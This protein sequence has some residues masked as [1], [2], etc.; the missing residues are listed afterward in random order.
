MGKAAVGLAS[1]PFIAVLFLGISLLTGTSID[2][3]DLMGM[4]GQAIIGQ[5]APQYSAIFDALLIV[6]A[7]VGIW[8]LLTLLVSGLTFK[9]FGLVM[10]IFALI[11][12]VI[13]LFNPLAGL[14]FG[15]VGYGLG[16]IL[17][18]YNTGNK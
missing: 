2:P 10:T 3:V 6:L 7:I 13:L 12:G 14:L 15:G 18:E 8:Q 11:G 16:F 17:N 9:V 5:L 1:S 4:V